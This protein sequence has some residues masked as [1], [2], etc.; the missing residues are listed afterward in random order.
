MVSSLVSVALF[1]EE[2]CDGV[3]K[4]LGLTVDLYTRAINEG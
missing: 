4:D 2:G 1:L 3:H